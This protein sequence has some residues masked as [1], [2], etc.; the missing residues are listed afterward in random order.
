[1]DDMSYVCICKYRILIRVCVVL[2]RVFTLSFI[3][4]FFLMIHNF[5][6]LKSVKLLTI[7]SSS[8]SLLHQVG[9]IRIS[10]PWTPGAQIHRTGSSFSPLT[11]SVFWGPR[12]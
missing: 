1:M 2:Q 10:I 6:T 7:Y 12:D 8:I 5:R 4:K 11:V 3:L 9:K